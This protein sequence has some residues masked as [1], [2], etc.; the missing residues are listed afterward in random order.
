MSVRHV[1][2]V[3][4]AKRNRFPRD[5][6]EHIPW[7]IHP[8]FRKRASSRAIYPPL[9]PCI[10]VSQEDIALQSVMQSPEAIPKGGKQPAG[11]RRYQPTRIVWNTGKSKLPPNE[12]REHPIGYGVFAVFRKVR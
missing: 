7:A 6:H 3:W 1:A 11:E 8:F 4:K 12:V 2:T 10:D 9:P 5:L